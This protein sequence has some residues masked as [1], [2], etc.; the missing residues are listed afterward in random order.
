MKKVTNKHDRRLLLK[1]L[2]TAVCR[3]IMLWAACGVISQILGD[4]GDDAILLVYLIALGHGRKH[5]QLSD[6]DT[7]QAGFRE[8]NQTAAVKK[9]SQKMQ[10]RL[11]ACVQ[12]AV[13]EQKEFLRAAISLAKA[14]GCT[15]EEALKNIC[16]FALAR[17]ME[18]DERDL[19]EF[20]REPEAKDY[21]RV[22]GPL[23]Y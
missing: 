17:G 18:L 19:Q 14:L 13:R 16:E 7:I 22:G 20:L 4:P 9:L 6:L 3:Q 23:D 8:I 15:R 21:N 12:S 11:L 1:K 2:R 5:L 10:H